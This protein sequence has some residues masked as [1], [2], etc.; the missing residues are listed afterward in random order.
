MASLILDLLAPR[1]MKELVSIRI[2]ESTVQAG[3]YH[4]IDTFSDVGVYPDY[5][6]QVT[7]EN[8]ADP[9]GWFMVEWIDADGVV[10]ETSIPVQGGTQPWELMASIDD[11]NANLDGSVIR[12][13]PSNTALVQI[14]VARVVRAY[15]SSVISLVTLESW[16]TPAATPDIIR[17]IAGKFIAAQLWANLASRS[18]TGVDNRAQTLY[19]EAM[20]LLNMII[21]G[22]IVIDDVTLVEDEG[23]ITGFDFFPTDATD[24]AFTMGMQL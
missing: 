24:R 22:Q 1:D 3:P 13:T 11:I 2:M 16:S 7:T 4:E 19:N 10:S 8:A 17:T 5:I 21:N 15:L 18:V 6:D 9:N 20:T 14:D 23:S 12:A